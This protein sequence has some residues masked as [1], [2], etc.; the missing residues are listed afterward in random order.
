MALAL[1]SLL[2]FVPFCSKF[3]VSDSLACN[4]SATLSSLGKT[5]SS[6]CFWLITIIQRPFM[7]LP[8][9]SLCF[10]R[11]RTSNSK[12][13]FLGDGDHLVWMPRWTFGWS[14]CP[15][16]TTNRR[17]CQASQLIDFI[18]ATW[19]QRVWIFFA[20]YLGPV[21]PLPQVECWIFK[22][23]ATTANEVSL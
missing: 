3:F 21:V 7:M 4:L 15:E 17:R 10:A 1:V 16:I 14:F 11:L 6:L 20:W 8:G 13:G 18:T 9:N 19:L 5:A 2:G 23:V 22:Q 12:R